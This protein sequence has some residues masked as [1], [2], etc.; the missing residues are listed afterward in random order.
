MSLL[1][2]LKPK[3]TGSVVVTPPAETLPPPGPG[4]KKIPPPQ[5]ERFLAGTAQIFLFANR[6]DIILVPT[7]KGGTV[8]VRGAPADWEQH[9]AIMAGTPPEISYRAVK[10]ERVDDD[11][12]DA[13]LAAFLLSR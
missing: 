7:A 6:P 9:L 13:V 11:F 5:I 1:L 10:D 4:S 3:K 12:H 2:L 8:I